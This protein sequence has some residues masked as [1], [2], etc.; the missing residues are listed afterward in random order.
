M[1]TPLPFSFTERLPAILQR[2]NP[3]IDVINVQNAAIENLE[4]EVTD[5]AGPAG[6]DLTL[7]FENGLV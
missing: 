1:P 6:P 4:A 5:L 2:I 7:L 3:M